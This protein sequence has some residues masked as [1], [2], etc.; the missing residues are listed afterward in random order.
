M[1]HDKPS[2]K[3]SA[4]KEKVF[5]SLCDVVMVNNPKLIPFYSETSTPDEFTKGPSLSSRMRKLN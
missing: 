1:K 2:Y 5:K 3:I 4:L